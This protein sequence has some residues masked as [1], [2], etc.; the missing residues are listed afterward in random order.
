MEREWPRDFTARLRQFAR[1]E[2]VTLFTVFAAAT[3]LLISRLSGEHRVALGVPFSNRAEP[4]TARL[5]GCLVTVLPLVTTISGEG[6]FVECLGEVSAAVGRIR[7]R[8]CD[9]R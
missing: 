7:A 3:Q 2:A 6:S 8:E 1:Q 5:V 4:E 9:A